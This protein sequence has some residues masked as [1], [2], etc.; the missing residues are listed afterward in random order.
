M[1]KGALGQKIWARRKELGLTAEKLAG[2]CGISRTYISKIEKRGYL[3]SVDI[4]AKI[5]KELRDA[6]MPY[7]R[8]YQYIKYPEILKMYNITDGLIEAGKKALPTSETTMISAAHF[9]GIRF[10]KKSTANMHE[11]TKEK[12]QIAVNKYNKLARSYFRSLLEILQTVEPDRA[13]K[14]KK[15]YFSNP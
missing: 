10:K 15:Q 5:I 4:L 6:P 1:D 8:V 2:K 9:I 13:E 3:P 7:F 12:Y 14:L 11:E